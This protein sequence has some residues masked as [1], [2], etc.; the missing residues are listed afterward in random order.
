MN[1]WVVGH[2]PVGHY[3]FDFPIKATPPPSAD[4]GTNTDNDNASTNKP[5]SSGSNLP[6]ELLG[7]KVFFMKALIMAG[8]PDLSKNVLGDTEGRWLA[9]E[10]IQGLVTPKYWSSVRN[11]LAE[12]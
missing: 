1:T 10:E 6:I 9:K 8:R 3:N 2:A 4:T 5:K 7:E 11:M 12:R